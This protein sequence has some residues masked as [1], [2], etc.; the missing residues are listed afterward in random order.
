MLRYVDDIFAVF[1]TKIYNFHDFISLLYNRFPSIKWTFEIENKDKSHVLDVLIQRNCTN[2]F[3]F[4]IFRK[5]T[6]NRRYIFPSTHII[7]DNIR[8]PVLT[9]FLFQFS[10]STVGGLKNIRIIKEIAKD[11]GYLSNL[12]TIIIGKTNCITSIN[13]PKS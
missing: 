3:E 1:S 9:F 8:W 2:M 12:K 13:L 10:H 11:N 6:H 7:A 5:W 4:D